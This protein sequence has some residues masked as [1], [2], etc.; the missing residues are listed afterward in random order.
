[1]LQLTVVREGRLNAPTRNSS[2]AVLFFVISGCRIDRLSPSFSAAPRKKREPSF[3]FLTSGESFCVKVWRGLDGVKQHE[4]L[5]ARHRHPVEG[6]HS[7]GLSSQG[8][9]N[10]LPGV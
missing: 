9:V 10:E 7:M 5:P 1:V 8:P 2:F 6:L 3:R 4:A